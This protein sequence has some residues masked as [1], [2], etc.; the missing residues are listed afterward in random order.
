MRL[1]YFEQDITRMSLFLLMDWIHSC[2]TE[3][4]RD[5]YDTDEEYYKDLSLFCSEWE[6]HYEKYKDFYDDDRICRY[7]K[8]LVCTT[9]KGRATLTTNFWRG[10]VSCPINSCE[11]LR[12]ITFKPKETL[13]EIEGQFLSFYNSVE[14]IFYAKWADEYKEYLHKY[15]ADK[16]FA[17]V[18]VGFSAKDSFSGDSVITDTYEQFVDYC[19]NHK[20]TFLAG[21]EFKRGNFFEG[22]KEYDITKSVYTYFRD[23]Y[24]G[25]KSFDKKM[26]V[27]LGFALSLPLPFMEKLLEYNGYSI[28]EFSQRKGDQIIRR[29]FKCGFSREMTIGLIDI[30]NSKGYNIPNLTKNN[31]EK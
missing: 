28:S 31:K 6:K 5:K 25:E 9:L 14:N 13:K 12:K 26:F 11:D 7:H 10:E 19:N 21:K 1:D 30:E 29:A 16:R 22:L 15:I 3:V 4:T 2:R 18:T 27:N 24:K 17:K 8:A 23:Y 20:V